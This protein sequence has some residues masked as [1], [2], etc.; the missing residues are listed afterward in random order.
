MRA[1]WCVFPWGNP[2]TASCTTALTP[3]VCA[4]VVVQTKTDPTETVKICQ[5]LLDQRDVESAIRVGDVYAVLVEYF[6]MQRNMEQAFRLIESMRQRGIV[7]APFLDADLIN[8][9]YRCVARLLI[10]PR[11]FFGVE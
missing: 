7:L 8:T 9:V 6:Y 2:R 11:P 4:C 10:P 3:C 5:Q 1:S